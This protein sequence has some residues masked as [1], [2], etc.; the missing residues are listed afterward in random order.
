MRVLYSAID[1]RVPGAKGGSVH[2]TAVAEGLAAL[3]HEVH[4]LASPGD[5]PFPEGAVRWTAMTPPLGA[6]RK[7]VV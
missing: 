1:Q 5:G 6:D 3:G 7:S 4:V 2:V